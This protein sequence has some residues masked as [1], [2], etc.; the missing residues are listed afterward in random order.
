M[1]KACRNLVGFNLV[2]CNL[3]EGGAAMLRAG[4]SLLVRG[5]NR[6]RPQHPRSAG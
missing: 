6:Q 4:V 1:A 2:A 3:I 5:R